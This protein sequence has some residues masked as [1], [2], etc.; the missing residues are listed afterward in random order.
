MDDDDL[1]VG[2]VVAGRYEVDGRVGTGGMGAVFAA[3]D[4]RLGRKVALK[5]LVRAAKPGDAESIARRRLEAEARIVASL[6]HPSIVRIYDVVDGASG[7]LLVMELVSGKSL[8]HRLEAGPLSSEEIAHVVTA[9]AD[10]LSAA[11]AQGLVHRDIKPENVM[12]RDD[13][14]VALLD[15]GIAKIVGSVAGPLSSTLTA[16]GDLLGTPMYLA[17]EQ[18]EAGVI[19]PPTDQFSLAVMAYELVTQHLPW[20]IDSLGVL[21]SDIL[22]RPPPALAPIEEGSELHDVFLQALDKFP[23]NRFASITLFASALSSALGVESR[24]P[25]EAVALSRSTTGSRGKPR[26]DERKHDSLTETV[27]SDTVAPSETPAPPV[28]PPEPAKHLTTTTVDARPRS[29]WMPVVVGALAL[30]GVA[31]LIFRYAA[32]SSRAGEQR[33]PTAAS[34]AASAPPGEPPTSHTE[35]AP[36]LESYRSALGALHVA[37]MGSTRRLLDNAIGE[38]GHF[39]SALLERAYVSLV[40][41]QPHDAN[42]RA[43]FRA[44]VAERTQLP[45][46]DAAFLDAM[47]PAFLDPPDWLAAR[48][49]LE[50]FAQTHPKDEQVWVAIAALDFKSGDLKGTSAAIDRALEADAKSGLALL[51]RAQLDVQMG[52]LEKAHRDLEACI[53]AVPESIGCRMSFAIYAVNEGECREADRLARETA[54]F[55]PE[56]PR[57]YD[58]RAQASAGLGADDASIKQLL[59]QRQSVVPAAELPLAKAM[60]AYRLSMRSGDFRV[61]LEAVG[62]WERLSAGVDPLGSIAVAKAGVLF[63][64]GDAKQAGT[65]ADDYLRLAAARA[66]PERSFLD[67]TG[68][69]LGFLSAAR[70]ADATVASRSDAWAADWRK[71]LGETG[72]NAYGQSVWLDAFYSPGDP[73]PIRARAALAARADF[74]AM[75]LT[76]L[77]MIHNPD[78]GGAYATSVGALMLAVDD[79]DGAATMLQWAARTCSIIP[80]VRAH[81]LLGVLAEKRHDTAAACA[82][83]AEVERIWGHATP[84]SVTAESARKHA[85]AC[86]PKP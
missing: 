23:P 78:V 21:L 8:R 39:A 1:K 47:T 13:G 61:A 35:S 83:F 56:Q 29:R 65:V 43:A 6:E 11:H 46:R 10:G 72:W 80:D 19:G 31:G 18:A 82:S 49:N 17:P 52:D 24:L 76:M 63:E 67:P 36:A 16:S 71:R 22:K 77:P 26:L 9:V 66:V 58:T 30:V 32:P 27:G 25:A 12:I 69:L 50:A 33:A 57:V 79:L 7:L 85:R 2:D 70:P 74:H 34:A 5:T 4:R 20:R 37:D 53:R 15:F 68:R 48:S 14:R 73:D 75:T 86:P 62:D 42:G 40:L 60:D 28:D 51:F 45:A 81:Y 54:A 84:K 3:T 41:A 59:Q 64:M 55:A 38:D 44:A